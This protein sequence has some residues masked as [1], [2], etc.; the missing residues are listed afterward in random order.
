MIGRLVIYPD[1]Q[2]FIRKDVSQWILDT[3]INQG[4]VEAE[5]EHS[6]DFTTMLAN[7]RSQK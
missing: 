6:R 5:L 3:K 2:S 4:V 7:L 1:P